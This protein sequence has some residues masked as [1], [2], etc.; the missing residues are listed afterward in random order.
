MGQVTINLTL[1]NQKLTNS[2]RAFLRYIK[3]AMNLYENRE[4]EAGESLS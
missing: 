2:T 4:T 3:T 1:M